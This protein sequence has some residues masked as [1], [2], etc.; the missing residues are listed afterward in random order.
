[1]AGRIVKSQ[2]GSITAATATG[3]VTI[4]STTGWYAGAKGW[5]TAGG[6]PN[7][8]VTIVEILSGTQ[9][10]VR[11]EPDGTMSGGVAYGRSNVA[12][13]NGGTIVQN[14][15]LIYNTADAPLT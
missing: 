7:V 14:E 4:A 6:Q 8:P 13:Y 15:Q 9:L 10:G 12:V 5:M 2:T 1:M 3:Y 11:I